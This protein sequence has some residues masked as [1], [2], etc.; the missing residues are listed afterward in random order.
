MSESVATTVFFYTREYPHQ[1][2]SGPLEIT[3]NKENDWRPIA[4]LEEAKAL[5]EKDATH[6]IYDESRCVTTYGIKTVY[7]VFDTKDN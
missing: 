3:L 6:G 5:A 1:W 2:T 7:K 4:S